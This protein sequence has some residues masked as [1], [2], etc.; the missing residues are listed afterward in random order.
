MFLRSPGRFN[1]ANALLAVAV[2]GRLGVPLPSIARAL[3]AWTAPAMRMETIT[4]PGGVTVLSDVYNAAPA[5]VIGALETLRDL[6]A[7]GKRVAVLGEMREL[8]P[9]AAEAHAEVGRAAAVAAPDRL[10][11]VGPLTGPLGEAARAA[12]Y[13][14]H[15][16]C[17]F[18]STAEAAG[19]LPALVGAGDVVLV[20]GSRALAMEKIVAALAAG[21][22]AS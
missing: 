21:G 10:V 9:F 5:S 3:G 11:L 8:G 12:G 14:D 16:V 1:V 20:K 13:P 4:T 17:R 22:G 7:P 2:G 19:T 15:A 6:P 18:D